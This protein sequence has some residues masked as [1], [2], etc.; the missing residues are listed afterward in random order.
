M[1]TLAT[2]ST[3]YYVSLLFLSSFFRH[4]ILGVPRTIATSPSYP[5]HSQMLHMVSRNR[6]KLGD[7]PTKFKAQ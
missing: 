6:L 7:S 5:T 1:A 4:V 2:V 3:D